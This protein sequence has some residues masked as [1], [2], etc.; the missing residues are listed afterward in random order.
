MKQISSNQKF[1]YYKIIFSSTTSEAIL[2]ECQRSCRFVYLYSSFVYSMLDEAVYCTESA[3]FLSSEKQRSFG[4]FV[5]RDKR[6]AIIFHEIQRL[7][8]GNQYKK[9]ATK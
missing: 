5:T 6:I 4:S 1:R 9:D 7:N 8:I 2:H 3:M